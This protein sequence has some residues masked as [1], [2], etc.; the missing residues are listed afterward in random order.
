MSEALVS[1]IIPAYNADQFVG[2]AIKSVLTQSHENLELIVVDDGST[3]RT[4]EIAE[5]FDDPR[6]HVLRERNSGPAGARNHGLALARGDVI[7]FLDADDYWLPEKLERQLRTLEADEQVSAVG[8]L[9]HYRSSNGRVLG[10]TGQTVDEHDQERIVRG[11][12]LPFP[13]SSSLF[14]R[15]TLDIVGEFDETLRDAAEDLDLMA[16]VASKGRFVCVDEVLGAYRIHPGSLS[17]HKFALQRAQTRFI[18]ARLRER[19]N[20]ADLSWEEFASRYRP[21]LRQRHDDLVRVWYRSAG[22]NAAE[23][24]WSKALLFGLLAV[25]LGPRYTLKRFRRQRLGLGK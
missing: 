1:V 25:V 13:L 24:R 21:S 17:V 10:V 2:D 6:L 3:D 9:M 16:R 12:L 11:Q 15:S 19:E 18:R 7:A 5:A 22:L 23:R 4:A 8:C 20:G 14:R